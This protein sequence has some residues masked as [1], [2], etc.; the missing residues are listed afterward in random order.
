MLMVFGHRMRVMFLGVGAVGVQDRIIL[1]PPLAAPVVVIRR[2]I[3]E[4]VADLVEFMR[5]DWR[6]PAT[7]SAGATFAEFDF[8]EGFSVFQR[9]PHYGLPELTVFALPLHVFS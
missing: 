4:S 2:R 3:I 1:R 9:Q 6:E 8:L 7:V 5:L